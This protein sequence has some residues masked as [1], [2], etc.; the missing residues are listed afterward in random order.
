VRAELL[1]NAEPLDWDEVSGRGDPAQRFRI[2]CRDHAGSLSL[3]ATCGTPEAVGVA[4]ITLGRERE[5][6]D[7]ALGIL[8]VLGEKGERWVLQPW[9]ASAKNVSDAG[10]T[11]RKARFK[12]GE[13]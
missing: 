4:I 9:E 12:R 8:D 6:E 10:R 2:Y 7:C 5:F 1:R 11:L 13:S 3:I